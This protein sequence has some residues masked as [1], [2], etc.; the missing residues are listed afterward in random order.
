MEDDI[1]AQRVG[2][3]LRRR[4]KALGMSQESYA[5]LV[6]V[7]RNYYGEVE[8]GERNLTLK[9]IAKICAGMKAKVWEVFSDAEV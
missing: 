2:K 6:N 7:H 3:A 5:A 4:R 8:R 1:V 9:S